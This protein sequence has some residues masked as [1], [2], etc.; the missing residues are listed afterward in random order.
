MTQFEKGD[1]SRRRTRRPSTSVSAS[2]CSFL[3]FAIREA[4]FCLYLSSSSRLRCYETTRESPSTNGSLRSNHDRN[5][6][7]LSHSFDVNTSSSYPS[8]PP[9]RLWFPPPSLPV[10]RFKPCPSSLPSPDPTYNIRR[11]RASSLL[12]VQ[13]P[14]SHPFPPL[15]LRGVITTSLYLPN[16]SLRTFVRSFGSVPISNPPSSPLH[17]NSTH[18][19]LQ[20]L[21][22]LAI[23]FASPR[24]ATFLHASFIYLSILSVPHLKSE[25]PSLIDFDCLRRRTDASSR[26]ALNSPRNASNDPTTPS[27]HS[28]RLSSTSLVH[29]LRRF[30]LW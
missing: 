3:S 18:L 15:Q 8:G 25:S 13:V 7:L 10:G 22:R 23:V 20:P 30:K 4:D 28:H 6:L 16:L 27:L 11:I 29:F 2:V 12:L 19:V 26:T 21:S 17:L 9:H 1:R 14:D 24:S 5:P